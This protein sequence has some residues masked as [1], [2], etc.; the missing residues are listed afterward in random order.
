MVSSLRLH[1][2]VLSYVWQACKQAAC[3]EQNMMLL[4]SASHAVTGSFSMNFKFCK[5]WV[6]MEAYLKVPQCTARMENSK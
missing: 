2:Q 3:A 4:N 1:E 5:V 6:L